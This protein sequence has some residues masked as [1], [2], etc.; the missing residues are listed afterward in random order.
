MQKAGPV[1]DDVSDVT[2]PDR[3]VEMVDE[4]ERQMRDHLL[5]ERRGVHDRHVTLDTNEF[6]VPT[7]ATDLR[8]WPTPTPKACR[9]AGDVGSLEESCCARAAP[10]DDDR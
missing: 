2:S 7:T 5:D 10:G 6:V 3:L 1:G 9:P 4:L 8:M